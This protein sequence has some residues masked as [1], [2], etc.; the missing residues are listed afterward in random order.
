M[1]IL[2]LFLILCISQFSFAQQEITDAELYDTL[3]KANGKLVVVEYYATWCKTCRSFE[4]AI[5][6]YEKMFGE[7]IDFYKMDGDKNPIST[8]QLNVEA[9]PSIVV[10]HS[11]TRNAKMK[12]N[13]DSE[14]TFIRSIYDFTM[15]QIRT[16]QSILSYEAYK[17][18][19]SVIN[20]KAWHAY[21]NIDNKIELARAKKYLSKALKEEENY[22]YLDTHAALLYKMGQYKKA[23]A[24]LVKAEESAL[25]SGKT[26]DSSKL[27]ALIEAK[28]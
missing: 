4:P 28:L 5:E 27:R 9:F 21:E 17:N 7:K 25:I 10:F 23:M 20:I 1:R 2:S 6:R 8:T 12:N 18:Q 14:N 13:W 3:V 15:W 22:A 11:P 24:E 16:D 19:P 26:Y